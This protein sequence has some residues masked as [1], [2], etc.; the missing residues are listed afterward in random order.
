[1]KKLYCAERNFYWLTETPKTITIDWIPQMSGEYELDQNVG[2][3]HLRA[4]KNNECNHCLKIH[5]NGIFVIYP[6]RC[7]TPMFLEPANFSHI[8]KE[9]ESCQ[10][11]GVSPKYYE[12]LKK[13]I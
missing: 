7:G 6:N 13:F 1:M 2:Y 12:D 3:K 9:I 11:W 8:E 10:S 5:D 4:K